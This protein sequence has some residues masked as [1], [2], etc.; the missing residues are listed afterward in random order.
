MERPPWQ[1]TDELERWFS[2]KELAELDII[3]H[4]GR[5]LYPDSIKQRDP[6]TG[7]IK[8]VPVRLRVPNTREKF[9]ARKMALQLA[10]TWLGELAPEPLTVGGIQKAA[11]PNYWEHVDNVCLLSLC[12]FEATEPYARYALPE[13]LDGL[14]QPAA[15]YELFDRLDWWAE[16]EDPRINESKLTPEAVVA[17]AAA[18]ARRGHTGPLLAIDGRARVSC[19]ITMAELLTSSRTPKSSSPSPETSTEG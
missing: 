1:P 4:E 11:G 9:Q 13:V 16:Q 15:L 12:T 2:G 6:K 8:A 7:A 14:H 10:K 19:V 5:A 3:E 18:I 17:V